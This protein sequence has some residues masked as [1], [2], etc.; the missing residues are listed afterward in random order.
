[1]PHVNL[2]SNINILTTLCTCITRITPHMKATDASESTTPGC[3]P[4]NGSVAFPEQNSQ[5]SVNIWQCT[6]LAFAFPH[7]L[8]L[9]LYVLS[10]QMTTKKIVKNIPAWWTQRDSNG[11]KALPF[12][13]SSYCKFHVMHAGFDASDQQPG[14]RVTPP[15]IQ[16]FEPKN[17]QVPF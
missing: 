12:N 9:Q 11:Y 16:H 13:T 4:P 1:M 17:F 14:Y 15:E 5:I 8:E 3:R 6:Y 7:Q 10:I 2:L